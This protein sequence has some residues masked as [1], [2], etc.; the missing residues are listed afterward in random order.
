MSRPRPVMTS[1]WPL[2]DLWPLELSDSSDLRLSCSHPLGLVSLYNSNDIRS[3][4]CHNKPFFSKAA[5]RGAIEW[6]WLPLSLFSELLHLHSL[7]SPTSRN[8]HRHSL[9]RLPFALSTKGRLLSESELSF[10]QMRGDLIHQVMAS[11]S[12][13]LAWLRARPNS[14]YSS[15]GGGV[16]RLLIKFDRKLL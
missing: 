13:A 11:L 6:V 14:A 12:P 15:T 10:L 2:D 9:W 3:S 5:V 4:V 1:W 16:W 7:H 8:C